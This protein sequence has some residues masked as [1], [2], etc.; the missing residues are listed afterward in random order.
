M[1]R[2]DDPLVEHLHQAQEHAQMAL[3]LLYGP[4]RYKRSLW[5]R[6]R[7]GRA[8]NSLMTLLVREL[9]KEDDGR[10]YADNQTDSDRGS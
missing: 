2:E 8:Q 4:S 5:Y 3:N 6:L 1:P 7:L 9:G 10:K